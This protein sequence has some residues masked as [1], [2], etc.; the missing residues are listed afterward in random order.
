MENLESYQWAVIR[1]VSYQKQKGVAGSLLFATVT[2]LSPDRPPPTKMFGCERHKIGS[3]E[4]NIFFRRVVLNASD[5]VSW[6][7]SLGE[8]NERS[9]RPSRLGDLEAAWDGIPISVSQVIDSPIWPHFGL[10][11]GEGIFA[12][13]GGRSNP[14]PFIGSVPARVHCRLGVADGY[15]DFLEND[16]SIAWVF[17]RMH[18]DLR[19]YP[20]YLGGASLV[21]PDPII[22]QI[23]NFLLPAVHDKSERIFYRFI[24]RIN[25]SLKYLTITTFDEQRHLLT[26]FKSQQIPEDGILEIEKGSTE[27]TH[28]YVITHKSH[29]VLIYSPPTGFVRKIVVNANVLSNKKIKVVAPLSDSVDSG[30][31]EYDAISYSSS[32]MNVVDEDLAEDAITKTA[33]AVSKREMTMAGL[34]FGQRW[35]AKGQRAEA[36]SFIHNELREA[37]K[38]IIIADPYLGALQLGQFLYAVNGL[39]VSVKLITSP[40]AFKRKKGEGFPENKFRDSLEKLKEEVNVDAQTFIIESSLLHDRFL[41]VDEKVWFLGNS[42]NSLGEKSSLVVRLPN[43]D[44]VIEKLNAFIEGA[45]SLQ[46]FCEKRL[47]ST[48]MV[49]K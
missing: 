10:P 38:R 13:F 15:Q 11:I 9:P 4:I 27:D 16:N 44:E 26:S 31:I 28:G 43:P 42:L 45:K 19:L 40:N 41:V 12:Q 29:G 8:G 47:K 17:R 25:Q 46:L 48:K 34:R 35:I 6:Y 21:V 24:P 33:S 37:R 7:R 5:A 39:S 20:E 23:D 1:L 30:H 49:K 14:A 2:L 3:S 22:K 32:S 36:M 18:I